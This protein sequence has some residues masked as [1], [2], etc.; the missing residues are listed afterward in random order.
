[1]EIKEEIANSRNARH[2]VIVRDEIDKTS[3]SFGVYNLE[4]NKINL[5]ALLKKHLE[6]LDGI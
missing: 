4:Y 3:V 2:R 1:M 6:E 5:K